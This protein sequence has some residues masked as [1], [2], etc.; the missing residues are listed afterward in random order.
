MGPVLV[1]ADEPV[2]YPTILVSNGLAVLISVGL[3]HTVGDSNEVLVQMMAAVSQ[4]TTVRSMI[5]DRALR[6]PLQKND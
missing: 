3:V 5:S 4:T 2:L 1:Q 6:E